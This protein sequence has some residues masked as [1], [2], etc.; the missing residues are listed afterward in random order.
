MAQYK[1]IVNA[2]YG[3]LLGYTDVQLLVGHGDRPETVSLQ[4]WAHSP[5][6]CFNWSTT[7]PSA[8][9]ISPR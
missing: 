8:S 6:I 9:R 3:V 5:S 7:M 4:A 2:L 1:L